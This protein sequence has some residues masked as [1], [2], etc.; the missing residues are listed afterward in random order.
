LL[1]ENKCS[2]KAVETAKQKDYFSGGPV[3][4]VDFTGN[5]DNLDRVVVAN[6]LHI[7]TL[8]QNILTRG[9]AM[10]IQSTP[11][12]APSHVMAEGGRKRRSRSTPTALQL[13]AAGQLT[14]TAPCN[15]MHNDWSE[16]DKSAFRG[17]LGKMFGWKE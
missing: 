1:K 13:A 10:K 3:K 15:G 7:T 6:D 2:K 5:L 8:T 16:N 11:Q 12:N 9:H 14:A 4:F 17:A